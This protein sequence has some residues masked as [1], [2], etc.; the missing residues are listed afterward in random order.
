M[1]IRSSPNSRGKCLFSLDVL[2]INGGTSDDVVS[3]SM[4]AG[5]KDKQ[6]RIHANL[7]KRQVTEEDKKER[8]K[9]TAKQLNQNKQTRK[10]S[11]QRK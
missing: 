2:R 3:T 4:S 11:V 9:E 10:E 1:Q 6:K 5:Q 8:V 7:N